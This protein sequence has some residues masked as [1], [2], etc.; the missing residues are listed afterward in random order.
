M[1]HIKRTEKPLKEKKKKKSETAPIPETKL[2]IITIITIISC[3]IM[4]IIISHTETSSMVAFP[5]QLAG[6]LP[7]TRSDS[8]LDLL[9]LRETARD[10]N[11]T[12]LIKPV[13]L[14]SFPQKLTK[15]GVIKVNYRHQNSVRVAIF[16]A[17]VNG[18]VTFGNRN[19]L[20]SDRILIH[21]YVTRRGLRKAERFR[22][23]RQ[24]TAPADEL[25]DWLALALA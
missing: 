10:R 1:H 20:L 5:R 14:L 18:Q 19:R 7:V 23:V 6:T 25:R 24:P 22:S 15:Q 3:N 2:V 4:F 17:H 21:R 11:T 13:L 12:L 8:G 9:K 16:L